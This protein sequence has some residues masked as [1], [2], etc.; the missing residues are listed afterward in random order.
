V[1]KC[2]SVRTLLLSMQSEK[3]GGKRSKKVPVR[4]ITRQRKYHF[5]T[6]EQTVTQAGK[7]EESSPHAW[8]LDMKNL[9]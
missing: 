9:G 6:G 4:M 8:E 2:T 5:G 3:E 1:E 7:R